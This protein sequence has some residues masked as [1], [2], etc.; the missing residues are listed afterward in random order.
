ML[1]FYL[2]VRSNVLLMFLLMS[3]TVAHAQ[4]VVSGKVTSEEDGA[5]V[6]GAN[7]SEK[8][9]TNGTV[10]DADGNYRITVGANATLV[11]S[12]IGFATQEIVVGSQS[13]IN[14]VLKSDVKSL[15]EV[16]VIGYGVANKR[17]LTGSIVKLDGSV[18][19]DKPNTDPVA[20]LQGKVAGLSVVNNGTP[21]KSAD[22]RIRGTAS[23]GNVRPL[24]VV[25]GI[26][27]DNIDYINPNDIESIEVLKDPSSLAIFGVRGA[28]GV[29]LVT[30]KKAKE[31]K[32]V[33][34]FNSTV[35]RKDL[36]NPIKMVNASDFLTLYN[37][38]NQNNGT[39]PYDLSAL[40]ANTNWIDAVTRVGM[41]QTNNLSIASSTDRNKFNVG[42]GYISDDGIILRENLKK[43]TIS[44]SDEAKLNK[45]L[46][47][48]FTFNTAYQIN[49]YTFTGPN[50][51]RLDDARK[52]IPQ[53]S[54][55]AKSFSVQDPYSTNIIN[56]NIYSSLDVALQNSGVVNPILEIENT[57]DKVKDVT[58]RYVGSFYTDVNFLKDFNF[59]ATWYGDVSY[60]NKRQYSPLY[61]AY[62]PLNDTPFLYNNRTSIVQNDYNWQ[63]FQGDYIL[64]YKKSI[65]EH[66]LTASAGVTHYY[67]GYSTNQVTVKQ[68]T[69]S[70]DLP[71]PNDPRFWYI[72]TGFGV[73]DPA[74]TNSDQSEYATLSF[75]GRVMY[76][77]KGKYFL[78]ASYRDD[79]TS[80]LVGKNRWQQFWSV[81]AAWELTQENFVQNIRQINFL[82]IKASYGVL[83]NQTASQLDGTPINY[84][85]YPNV[86]TG[87]KAV[88]GNS[89]YN[90]YS[91]AYLNNPNLKWETVN[92]SE[93]GLELD[94]F[95]NRLHVEAAYFNR[96]TN[97]L[98]TFIDRSSLGLQNELINGGSL[99]NW[100]Q[101]ISA[102]WKQKITNDLR[103]DVGGNVTFLKNEVLSLSQDLPN[104]FLSRSFM[105][106]GS[107]ESRTIVG[108]PIGSFFGYKVAGL[109]QTYADV[110]GSPI[111][112]SI[113]AYG[114]GDFKFQQVSAADKAEGVVT[115]SS[116]T[117]IGNPTPK[118]TYGMYVNVNYKQF[119]LSV[120]IQGVYG[121][122]I[123]RTWGSLESPYQR[124][125][126][127]QFMMDRWRGPGTSNWQPIISQGHRINYNGSTYNLEDGSYIRFRNVQLAYN[128]HPS[129]LSSLKLTAL[130]LYINWQN[131]ITFKYNNGY[132]PEYG[133]DATAFGYDNGGNAI[134]RVTTLGLNVTF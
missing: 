115:A 32:T 104:G 1:K 90:A 130:K 132:S 131:L 94:A 58:T 87:N 96:T 29:I 12:F 40:K 36:V 30:T 116:R 64:N 93:V 66:N 97:D 55:F 70:S 42:L 24:Y 47:V 7:V 75:L 128:F 28:T 22:I 16:V 69:T 68:G 103:L 71:I 112:S 38:E 6:P 48:G 80:R 73:V 67:F 113:G 49:P 8:G 9:T 105:N 133:G 33:V 122:V 37:E 120:D 52:V 61:Y 98:M 23:I 51:N 74:N 125:N 109:F 99:R 92:A 17:D 111:Q 129:L 114:P 91:S 15:E 121:N 102:V 14:V 79:G 54:P 43:I 56:Q 41:R 82:K 118:F 76:N 57:W 34:N 60:E 39:T 117:V 100:G 134:P 107:A 108:Q 4:Q 13:T 89:I 27:N 45:N 83:G 72:S 25:D 65:G 127:A 50:D 18:V 95:D 11:F 126:Y 88:F 119:S 85:S 59:R 77:Y 19:A 123:F 31:G 35:A 2:F 26:L 86:V 46:K 5:G 44:L 53:V 81:G 10:S 106:N 21:G 3:F 62:N 63:K 78:N 101:E 124:V 20:S 84:P 110:L